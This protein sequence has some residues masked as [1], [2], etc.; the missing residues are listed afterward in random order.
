V[1]PLFAADQAPTEVVSAIGAAGSRW[2]D[3]DEADRRLGVSKLRLAGVYDD[4]QEGRFMLRTRI[5][6]GR[7]NAD[8]LE[9]VAGVVRDF[10]ARPEG[11]EGPDR[12][13]EITVQY[14]SGIR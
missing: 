4:R 9:A 8:Q 5:P 14:D 2:E 7:T 1:S 12:F 6:G 11:E 13:A 10:A 3:L